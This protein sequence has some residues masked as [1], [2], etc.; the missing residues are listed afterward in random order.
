MAVR[1][2]DTQKKKKRGKER[3]CVGKK[4]AGVKE[5]CKSD[6]SSKGW[7]EGERRGEKAV[8]LV[9]NK[10]TKEKEKKKIAD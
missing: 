10:Q 5:G 1:Q 9:G 7:M 2:C 3:K 4:E 8:V 6:G